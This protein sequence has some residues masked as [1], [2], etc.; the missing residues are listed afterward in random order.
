M[1]LVDTSK[2]RIISDE[3]I[4]NEIISEHPYQKWLDENHVLLSD[5][6]KPPR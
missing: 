4:K 2:G 1:F 6:P 3:E 5:L